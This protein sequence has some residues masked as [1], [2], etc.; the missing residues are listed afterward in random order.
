[1]KT[2]E[3]MKK[4]LSELNPIEEIKRDYIESKDLLGNRKSL[5]SLYK[6]YYNKYHINRR[7]FLV[8]L[9]EAHE[10]IGSQK[11]YDI[12]RKQNKTNNDLI[13]SDM[14]PHYYD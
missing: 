13:Y 8:I 4:D 2:P 10:D 9:N 6:K 7:L 11:R 3:Y 5:A 14:P 1:M 12:Y